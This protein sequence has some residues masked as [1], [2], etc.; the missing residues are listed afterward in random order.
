M[1][2]EV[3]S[4]LAE[5]DYA[6]LVVATL[7][8]ILLV[9][10]ASAQFV[11]EWQSGNIGYNGWGASYGYDVDGDGVPN[12]WVRASNQLLIYNP[13]YTVYWTISFSGYDYPYLTAPRDVDG[14]GLVSP[15]NMDADASGEVVVTAYRLSGSDYFGRIRVYDASSRQLEWESAEIAG[16]YGTA[17]VDDVD[18]DGKHEVVITR[19]N[20]TGNWGYVEVYGHAGAGTDEPDG[21]GIE[22]S[23]PIA[24]PNP[25]TG[26]AEIGFALARTV[27][28]RIVIFDAAG[29]EVRR[30]LDAELP[31]GQYSIVWDGLDECGSPAP[32]GVYEYRLETGAGVET[33]R[34]AKLGH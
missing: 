29:R 7:V 8:L 2:R 28:T 13:N 34:L 1:K 22:S 26:S 31:A 23:R 30:L 18:G 20:Y 15:V 6:R 3:R 27:R 11:R 32:A 17:S 21:Y 5:S 9:L 16:F 12:L 19:V 10:P 24:L 4:Q 25:C 33:G 14:D